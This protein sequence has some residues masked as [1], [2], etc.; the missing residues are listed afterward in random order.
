[1]KISG[2]DNP[3]RVGDVIFIHGLM[4]HPWDTWQS[5]KG[6]KDN[7]WPAWLGEE[8]PELGI[9]SLGYEIEPLAWQGDTLPLVERA[10]NILA[11][12]DAYNIGDRPLMFITHSMGGLLAKQM[13]H[14]AFDFGTA[15]W[16]AIVQQTQGI[17][18]LSTPHSGTDLT[19]WVQYIGTLVGNS[20]NFPEL[21]S[22]HSQLRELNLLYR[23]H[24]YLS[25][26]PV[27]VYCET[28]KTG[29]I[30]VVNETIADPGIPGVQP[31]A[32]DENHISICRPAAKDSLVYK[33]VKQFIEQQLQINSQPQLL[34][35]IPTNHIST[36]FH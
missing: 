29:D 17:V 36:T 26:I 30:L 8:L 13:L 21:E 25:K 33:R 6:E 9:W 20:I 32:I 34:E 35:T 16:Q 3:K 7:F 14:H 5:G 15:R 28:Q 18:Y 23:H 4:G 24:Q 10:I 12:F 27:E 19:S 22:T 2:C 1:M 31:I 11:L